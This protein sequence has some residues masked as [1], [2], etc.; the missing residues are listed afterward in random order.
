MK[1]LIVLVAVGVGGVG[2]YNG[3][4]GGVV[5]GIVMVGLYSLAGRQAD[6][7]TSTSGQSGRDGYD[8]D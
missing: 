4:V 1:I 3:N 7:G 5:A 8:H 6:H 2:L